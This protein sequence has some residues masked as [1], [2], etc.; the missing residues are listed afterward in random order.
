MK[1]TVHS[2]LEFIA[3]RNNSM[4]N[5]E[6]SIVAARC[7]PDRAEYVARSVVGQ[8][9]VQFFVQSSVIRAFIHIRCPSSGVSMQTGAGYKLTANLLI[10]QWVLRISVGAYTVIV[11]AVAIHIKMWNT[12]SIKT[13]SSESRF[14]VNA[15]PKTPS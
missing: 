1:T 13:R 4:H 8:M 11:A 3:I 5:N 14:L 6:T 12:A 10:R 15:L 7:D 9:R 2:T